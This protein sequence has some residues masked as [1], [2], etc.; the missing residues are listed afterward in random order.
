MNIDP[1]QKSI[2]RKALVLL[3]R[4]SKGDLNAAMKG[5]TR[6]NA[7]ILSSQ[8]TMCEEILTELDDESKTVPRM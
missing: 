3:L 4:Q 5:N 6:F 2:I 8:I 1:Y 7:G